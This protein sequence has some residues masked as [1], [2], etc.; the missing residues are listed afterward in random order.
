MN[1]LGVE[2]ESFLTVPNDHCSRAPQMMLA[3]ALYRFDPRALDANCRHIPTGSFEAATL[4]L[5]LA[6]PDCCTDMVVRTRRE[7]YLMVVT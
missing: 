7:G 5:G 3:Q 4:V 1:T 2:R 6:G